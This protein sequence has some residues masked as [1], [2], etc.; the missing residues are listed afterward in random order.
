MTAVFCD[1]RSCSLVETTDVSKERPAAIFTAVSPN[2][3]P[4]YPEN[5]GSTS[6]KI[7]VDFYQTT[8]CHIPEYGTVHGHFF[9][10]LRSRNISFGCSKF[11][12]LNSRDTKTVLAGKDSMWQKLLLAGNDSM[13]H[14]NC[15][16]PG[17]IL[18]DTETA[19]GRER[20]YVTKKLLLAG[21]ESMW[22]R[23]CCWSEKV[24][25]DANT[26]DGRERFYDAVRS[27]YIDVTYCDVSPLKSSGYYMYHQV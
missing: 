24:L 12:C 13:W 25:C 14:R 4:S 26:A 15:C 6:Y 18:C 1:V 5:G 2:S 19:A 21:K 20:F 23:N 8:R 10:N 17:K 9:Q 16:W 3:A 11:D 7:L 22:H 27:S